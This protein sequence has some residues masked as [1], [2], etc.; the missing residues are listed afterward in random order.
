MT[1]QLG[2]VFAT[3]EPTLPGPGPRTVVRKSSIEVY[4]RAGGLN[5]QI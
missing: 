5:I 1:S 3:F 4:V 2:H